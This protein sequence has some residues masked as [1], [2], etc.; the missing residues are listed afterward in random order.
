MIIVANQACGGEVGNNRGKS[1]KTNLLHFFFYLL[2]FERFMV[3]N[4]LNS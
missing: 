2:D 1:L 4:F 3:I